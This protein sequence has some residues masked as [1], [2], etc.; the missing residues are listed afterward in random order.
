ML[1]HGRRGR[2]PPHGAVH[3]RLRLLRLPQA[4]APYT[5]PESAHPAVALGR[6]GL[7]DMR[8]LG[9]VEAVVVVVRVAGLLLR[10]LLLLLE[11]RSRRRRRRRY[12]SRHCGSAR[13]GQRLPT[14][15]RGRLDRGCCR[16]RRRAVQRRFG[17]AGLRRGRV[18]R[19]CWRRCRRRRVHLTRRGL[20]FEV[21]LDLLVY[22]RSRCYRHGRQGAK[23]GAAISCSMLLLLPL[24]AAAA[25]CTLRALCQPLMALP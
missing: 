10:L 1:P 24:A 17:G 25:A 23:A 21:L 4:A 16:G 11:G 22:P 7:D 8:P 18:R 15:G 12:G 13:R 5:P 19:C 14:A 3:A 2:R 6:V 20:R 9:R